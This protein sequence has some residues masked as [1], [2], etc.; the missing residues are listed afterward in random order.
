MPPPSSPQMQSVQHG[1]HA[2]TLRG[3]LL[4]S[5]PTARDIPSISSI[6]RPESSM[7]ISS[8]LGSDQT[9]P[10]REPISTMTTSE[11]SPMKGATLTSPRMQIG[12]APSPTRNQEHARSL[13]KRSRSPERSGFADSPTPRPPRTC[14]GG[15]LRHSITNVN[16][17]SSDTSRYTS[18]LGPFNSQYSPKSDSS[19]LQD[20]KLFHDGRP[21]LKRPYERPNS[22]PVDSITRSS[23]FDKNLHLRP[24]TSEAESFRS[25]NIKHL[26]GAKL[27]EG[28]TVKSRHDRENGTASEFLDSRI[29]HAHDHHNLLP[30]SQES[31]AQ[32]PVGSPA[33]SFQSKAI[34]PSP[35]R[36]RFRRETDPLATHSLERN[37]SAPTQSPFIAESIRR[38]REGRPLGFNIPQQTLAPTP[39]G[40]S[41]HLLQQ[42]NGNSRPSM[43]QDPSMSLGPETSRAG[44][45]PEQPIVKSDEDSLQN[46]RSSLALLL[47]NSKRGRISPLPQAVQGA[48]ARVSGPASDPGIKSEFARMFIG[49]GSGVGR[50]G[51]LGS[52]TSTPFSPSPTKHI[53]PERKTPAIG[54]GEPVE[55]NNSWTGAKAGRKEHKAKNEEP[56]PPLEVKQSENS[57]AVT[58]MRGV[59]RTRHSHHHH[60]HQHS[61]Q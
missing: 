38:L 39:S 28:V 48:Q 8:M 21:I 50:V 9:R 18:S 33:F 26:Q 32:E 2:S 53:E 1:T 59:K 51:R 25:A 52:G 5:F 4:P 16:V 54:R 58:S 45:G 30:I 23:E 10:S 60:P 44:G 22:Q 61:H 27:A 31:P 19:P 17:G 35:D 15:A 47:D 36:A 6:T 49:I 11:H 7:S 12:A 56:R 41:I 40:S 3:P 37:Q 29:R 13:Y 57:A 43:S 55:L 34:P 42:G 46:H 20:W 14:S 24:L